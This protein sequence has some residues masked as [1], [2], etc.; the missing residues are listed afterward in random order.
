MYET[1]VLILPLQSCSVPALVM[2][3][4]IL[5]LQGQAIE[6]EGCYRNAIHLS[7]SAFTCW[8]LVEQDKAVHEYAAF[9]AQVQWN[10]QSRE[11]EGKKYIAQQLEKRKKYPFDFELLKHIPSW[12]FYLYR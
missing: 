6:A 10:R 3:G 8:D 9:L 1:L 12:M 7:N 5:Q 2:L 4:K 11:D